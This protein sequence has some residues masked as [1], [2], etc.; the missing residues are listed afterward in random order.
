MVEPTHNQYLVLKE[1][2]DEG[3]S[4][5]ADNDNPQIEKYWELVRAGYLKNLVGFLNDWKFILT[6]KAEEYLEEQCPK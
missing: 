3:S 5:D 2:E 6:E 4:V 1:I